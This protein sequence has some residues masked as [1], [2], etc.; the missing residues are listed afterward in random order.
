MLSY[1][2]TPVFVFF[3]SGHFFPQVHKIWPLLLAPY[4]PSLCIDHAMMMTSIETLWDTC[5]KCWGSP[6]TC[7]TFIRVDQKQSWNTF[8]KWGWMFRMN[9]RRSHWQHPC[10]H[11][12]FFFKNHKDWNR[13]SD[14][15]RFHTSIAG[16]NIETA[17]FNNSPGSA[18]I[19]Y[20]SSDLLNEMWEMLWD[21]AN[22]LLL[23]LYWF[24][25][26][27]PAFSATKTWES[28]IEGWSHELLNGL[29][30][31]DSGK[32]T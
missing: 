25:E 24:C 26:S 3:V 20:N 8:R 23:P 27:V 6:F 18:K 14:R 5:I 11:C 32:C 12:P 15:N 21:I 10:Y 4:I 28:L 22:N 30:P 29:M 31:T 2:L 17:Q 19:C 9:Q 13:L 1:V 7:C 16:M